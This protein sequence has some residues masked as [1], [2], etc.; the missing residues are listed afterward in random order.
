[1]FSYY[2]NEIF[3]FSFIRLMN[4]LQNTTYPILYLELLKTILI[5]VESTNYE[6]DENMNSVIT[7][8]FDGN[9][10]IVF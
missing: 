4:I 3:N 8:L 6:F 5:I 10:F 2:Y 1:M 9:S 7:C